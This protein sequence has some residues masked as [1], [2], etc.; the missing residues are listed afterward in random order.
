MNQRQIQRLKAILSAFEENIKSFT[1]D[2]TATYDEKDNTIA[3]QLQ[4]E[5]DLLKAN[6]EL[7]N[8]VEIQKRDLWAKDEVIIA[9]VDKINALEA[10]LKEIKTKANKINAFGKYRQTKEKPVNEP[11]KG[12]R[13][14]EDK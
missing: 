12:F 5:S 3:K 4:R 8:I 2:L 6:D 10:E 1:D 13:I 11:K 9:Q 14:K 7:R